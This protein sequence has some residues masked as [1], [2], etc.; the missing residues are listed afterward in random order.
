VGGPRAI[1]WNSI[2]FACER[3]AV[4]AVEN[5]SVKPE[6]VPTML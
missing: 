2:N 1:N 6:R 5:V 4:A 3:D